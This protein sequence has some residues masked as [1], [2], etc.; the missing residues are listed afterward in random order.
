MAARRVSWIATCIAAIA[1]GFT[2]LAASPRTPELAPGFET[3]L[4]LLDAETLGRRQIAVGERGFILLRDDGQHWR[5]AKTVGT[6]TLTA[7]TRRA[8]QLWVVGHDAAIL[9]STDHGASWRRVHYAPAQQRPLL[10]VLFVDDT[11]GFAVGAYGYFLE[12]VDAGEHWASRMI[13]SGDRHYN[14]IAMLANGN[15]LVAGEAGTLLRSIDLGKNWQP[16]T[17]PYAGS[18][19]G[20]LPIGKSGAVIFGLRGQLYR[21]EDAGDHWT[22]LASHT[23]AALMGGRILADGTVAVVGQDGV[24]LTSADQAQTFTLHQQPSNAAFATLIGD[25]RQWWLLGERGVTRT[26]PLR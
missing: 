20:V 19:F 16:L 6:S 9:K 22:A 8:S 3:R 11:H 15:L 25:K 4:L 26:A 14:S 13:A 24:V 18:W 5:P 12:T 21:T 7:I 17:S 1:F 2:S 10:D 23:G